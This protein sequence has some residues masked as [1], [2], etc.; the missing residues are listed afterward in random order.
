MLNHLQ[1]ITGKL[2]NQFPGMPTVH[3]IYYSYLAKKISHE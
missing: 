2:L 3:A 1:K